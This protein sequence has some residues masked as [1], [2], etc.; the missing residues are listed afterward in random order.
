MAA[1]KKLKSVP[2]DF[3][4]DKLIRSNPVLRPMFGCHAIYIGDT[5][6]M[7]LRRKQQHADDNGIWIAT[8]AMHHDSLKKDFPS[9]RTIELIGPKSGWLLLPEDSGDFEESALR[10]SALIL[11]RDTRIGKIPKAK[12]IKKD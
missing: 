6:M 10:L 7:M 2:F 1:P 9:L 8:T 5:I 12:K 3:V 4:V 11:R